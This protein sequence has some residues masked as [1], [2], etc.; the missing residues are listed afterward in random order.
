MSGMLEIGLV[1]YKL[2][3]IP[4]RKTRM[5]ADN[6]NRRDIGIR[7]DDNKCQHPR[8]SRATLQTCSPR[9]P[10]KDRLRY[11]CV[12]PVE[13]TELPSRRPCYDWLLLSSH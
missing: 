11:P 4:R 12:M 9:V 10:G 1:L 6:S 13:V 3:I 5:R 8:K 7:Y 2:A